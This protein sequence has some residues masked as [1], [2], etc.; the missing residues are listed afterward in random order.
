MV[1]GTPST[2]RHPL[3]ETSRSSI[4]SAM[5]L[6]SGVTQAIAYCPAPRRASSSSSRVRGRFSGVV[7]FAI[8][9]GSRVRCRWSR[10]PLT[11]APGASERS[12]LPDAGAPPLPPERHVGLAAPRRDVRPSATPPRP[13]LSPTLP[14][15]SSLPGHPVLEANAP[16]KPQSSRGSPRARL[17]IRRLSRA[18]VKKSGRFRGPPR[19]GS[20]PVG[21]TVFSRGPLARRPRLP[22]GVSRGTLS[23][24]ASIPPGAR[25]EKP[26]PRAP[27][28]RSAE[29]AG[30]AGVNL[31]ELDVPDDVDGDAVVRWLE[32]GEGNPW[33]ER[34][35]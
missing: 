14:R 23:S 33:R 16:T 8:E 30:L 10:A 7:F 13:T 5:R 31:A 15:G 35:R 11:T 27:S 6:G 18:T 20:I 32:T 12:T 25:A 4:A 28:Q 22:R 3:S 19:T 26:L 21:S 2:P 24:M 17:T 29:D 34:S 1:S 9:G